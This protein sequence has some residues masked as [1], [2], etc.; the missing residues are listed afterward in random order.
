MGIVSPTWTGWL[1][2]HQQYLFLLQ[3]S[4]GMPPEYLK[5]AMSATFKRTITFFSFNE[6]KTRLH[7][8]PGNVT[9]VCRVLG[10]CNGDKRHRIWDGALTHDKMCDGPNSPYYVYAD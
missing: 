5:F 1:T 8:N 4:S 2:M 7:V 10:Q 3:H 6:N 9:S